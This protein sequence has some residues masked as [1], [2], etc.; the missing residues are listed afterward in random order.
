MKIIR[1]VVPGHLSG[2]LR[3]IE[4]LNL[5]FDSFGLRSC[6]LVQLGA[7]GRAQGWFW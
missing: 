1:N 4:K 5:V 2:A 7:G 6:H 3:E